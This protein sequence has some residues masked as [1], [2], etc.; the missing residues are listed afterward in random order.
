MAV[1]RARKQK[2]IP[3]L[4]KNRDNRHSCRVSNRILKRNSIRHTRRH[5]GQMWDIFVAERILIEKI[6]SSS[7]RRNCTRINIL[8]DCNHL[9]KLRWGCFFLVGIDCIT[10]LLSQRVIWHT[11]QVYPLGLW[12]I[13]DDSRGIQVCENIEGLSRSRNVQARWGHR[14]RSTRIFYSVSPLCVYPSLRRSSE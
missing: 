12:D 7:T 1:L 11:G 4:R 6:H 13:L 14:T 8:L 2:V 3:F 5:F 9:V 10:F